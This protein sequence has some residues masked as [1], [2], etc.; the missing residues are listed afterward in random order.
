MQKWVLIILL[1]CCHTGLFAQDAKQMDARMAYYMDRLSYWYKHADA[2]MGGADSLENNNDLFIEYLERTVIQRDTGI[3]YPYPQAIKNGLNVTTSTDSIL[4]IYAWDRKDDPDREH[5]ENIAA[6]MTYYNVRYT[7][8]A[9]L[10]KKGAPGFFF[11]FIVPVHTKEGNIYLAAYHGTHSLRVEGIRAYGLVD[12]KLAKIPFF[13]DETGFYSDLAY[14]YEP[15]SASAKALL[16]FNEKHDKLYVPRIKDGTFA[17]K[18][19]VY[20]FDG[21]KFTYDKNAR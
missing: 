6:Y 9:S 15:D 18:F 1:T 7:D 12:H 2:T 14:D 16:H 10:E 3:F 21:N 4:R 19:V 20:T 17:G 5:M 8:L 13:K 11:D